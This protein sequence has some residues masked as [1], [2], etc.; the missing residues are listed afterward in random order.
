MEPN[1]ALG[2]AA[3][4]A[5]TLAGFAGVVNVFKPD[6]PDRWTRL[7][8]TRLQLLLHNSLCPLA[9]SLMGML[10][11]TIKPQP[12]SIWRWCSAFGLVFQ[13]PGAFIAFKNARHLTPDEFRHTSRILLYGIGAMG[14]L[15][16]LLQVYNVAVLNLFW[17][18][19]LSIVM[20]L[21]AGM[22]QFTRMVLLVPEKE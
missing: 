19:F 21:M 22:L 13:A 4:V 2:I 10:L 7:D 6:S 14:A 18:F 9:Y 8:R 3:Q 17:P 1:E 12:E 5:V 11:L 15:T 20:H 16:L